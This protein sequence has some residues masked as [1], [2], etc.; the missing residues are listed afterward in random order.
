[1]KFSKAALAALMTM[2]AGGVQAAL[3]P[4]SVDV[5]IEVT[6]TQPSCEIRVPSSYD[7]GVLV[8]G[9]SGR[10]H[11]PLHITVDCGGTPQKTALTAGTVGSPDKAGDEKVYLMKNGQRTG[12]MLSLKEKG[13]TDLIKLT[14]LDTDVFCK[15]TAG[16]ASRTCTLIPVTDVSRDGVLGEAS[17]TLRFGIVYL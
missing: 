7:L 9:E 16:S 3:S 10:E 13:A 12:A 6:F 17:A 2:M 1:M 8:H 4:A 14:G 15:D 5:S 11:T